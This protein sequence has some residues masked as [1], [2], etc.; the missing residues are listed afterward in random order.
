NMDLLRHC[1]K[2]WDKIR[3]RFVKGQH[4][5]GD[6]DTGPNPPRLA[7]VP[8]WTSDEQDSMNFHPAFDPD[9]S[10]GRG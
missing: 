4:H 8:T 5:A 10:C 7:I 6:K 3:G 9:G 1:L 2:L